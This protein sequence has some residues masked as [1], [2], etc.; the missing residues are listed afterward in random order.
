MTVLVI[1]A[2]FLTVSILITVSIYIIKASTIGYFLVIVSFLEGIATK[3]YELTIS[4]EFY[5][6][7]KKFEYSNYNL[8]YEIVQNL[9]RSTVVFL[10]IITNLDLK[11]MIY[12]SLIFV[13]LGAFMSF[14]QIGNDE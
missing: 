11:T 10:L 1:I 9:F 8:I 12:V 7:S 2:L 3:M 14:R 13:A 5:T 4:K 6:L